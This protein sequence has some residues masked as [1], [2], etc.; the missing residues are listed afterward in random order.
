[1]REI[2]ILESLQNDHIVQLKDCFMG[3]SADLQSQYPEIY[4]VMEYCK[5]DLMK[6]LERK[7]RFS[8]EEI[9]CIMYQIFDGLNYLHEK[10]ILH[11]DIKDGNILLTEDGVVKICD[12]GLAR[13]FSRDDGSVPYSDNKITMCYRPP[14]ILLGYRQ[15][16][17][18]IDIWSAGCIFLNLLKHGLYIR[19]DDPRTVFEGI[20]E[21]CGSRSQECYW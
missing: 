20:L 19:G 12:F 7:V 17:S 15:Y 1:M 11:R 2:Q 10:K 16:T 14:E 4:M 3:D 5:Y 18:K 9:K 6:L 8:Q 13:Y 21:L